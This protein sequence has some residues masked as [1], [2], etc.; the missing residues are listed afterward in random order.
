MPKR[1]TKK[2][3]ARTAT[4]IAES[5]KRREAEARDAL[6]DRLVAVASECDDDIQKIATAYGILTDKAN[7]AAG[8]PTSILG[9]TPAEPARSSACSKRRWYSEARQPRRHSTAR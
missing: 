6:L 5:I 2:K 7:L 1:T 3:V 9:G 4:Q 8:R